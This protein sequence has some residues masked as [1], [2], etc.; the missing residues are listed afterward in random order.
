MSH[1][2]CA[3]C[4]AEQPLVRVYIGMNHPRPNLLAISCTECGRVSSQMRTLGDYLLFSFVYGCLAALFV[5]L[6]MFVGPD[7]EITWVALIGATVP[8][9]FLPAW[10]A[11]HVAQRLAADAPAEDLTI[12]QKLIYLLVAIT[13]IGCMVAAGVFGYLMWTP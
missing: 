6:G 5:V 1:A 12:A 4:G 9:L 10:W 3:L 7:V 13:V 2:T 8:F 11:T